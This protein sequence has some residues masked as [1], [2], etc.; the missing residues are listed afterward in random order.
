MAFAA[1]T[2]W[3]L[4]V[5]PWMVALCILAAVMSFFLP[6]ALSAAARRG[7]ATVNPATDSLEFRY[8]SYMRWGSICV[9]I[10]VLVGITV[11]VVVHPPKNLDETVAIIMMYAVSTVLTGALVWECVRFRVVVGSEGIECRSPWQRRRFIRWGD[12]VNVSF[13]NQLG[14]FDIHTTGR[15]GIRVPALVGGLGTILEACERRLTPNQLMPALRA[16]VLLGRR[17]PEE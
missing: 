4:V 3:A 11:M 16:Y 2:L 9:A 5:T 15:R 1:G 6:F 13:D 12:V 7:G 14:H 17:F 8:Q 10:G